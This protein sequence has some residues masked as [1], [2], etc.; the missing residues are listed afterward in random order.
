MLV[1]LLALGLA[2]APAADAKKPAKAAPA[3]PAAAA[4]DAQPKDPA[5]ASQGAARAAPA[6]APAESDV[7]G[8]LSLTNTTSSRD[9]GV[10]LPWDGPGGAQMKL[11]WDALD[12]RNEALSVG[13][14][15]ARA[16][17]EA[18]R[19]YFDTEG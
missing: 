5:A 16:L 14:M 3:A 7:M 4:G 12:K 13:D 1:L 17:V 11:S 8:F 10:K 9:G 2:A 18:V 15:M 19:M 6:D